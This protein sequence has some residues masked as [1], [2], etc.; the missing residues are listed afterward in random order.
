MNYVNDSLAALSFAL[1]LVCHLGAVLA[2][3]EMNGRPDDEG[4]TGSKNRVHLNVQELDLNHAATARPL[5]DG[6]RVHA[7]YKISL[8][9]QVRDCRRFWLT[10]RSDSGLRQNGDVC[11]MARD[12][13]R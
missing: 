3:H 2:I 13:K 9:A 10:G 1:W 12:L 8:V 7:R 5:N 6:L 4:P 11:A